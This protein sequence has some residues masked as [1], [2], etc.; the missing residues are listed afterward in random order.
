MPDQPG[1]T[2]PADPPAQDRRAS[3]AV[4]FT[5]I[6]RAIAKRVTDS[7]SQP[8]FTVTAS[9]HVDALLALRS[10]LNTEPRPDGQDDRDD[11]KVSLN[12]LLIGAVG[13]AL[14]QHPGINASYTPENRGQ[15]LIH[16]R[17]NIG[18]AVDSPAGLM[19]PVLHDADHDSLT[20][21]ARKTTS[22]IARTQARDL[23]LDDLEDGTFTISNLGM[24]GIDHFTALLIP[25][26]GAILAI[27]GITTQLT[28]DHGEP[29]EH[30][31]LSYTLTAD[32]RIIDGA[33]AARFLRTL[34]SI[35]EQPRP[36]LD[37]ALSSS[38]DVAG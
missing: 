21:L 38:P 24:L 5:P 10:H 9:A 28:L 15:Q 27:G 17:I 37:K 20:D 11:Q 2:T 26:Q 33:L 18:I 16:D 35:L 6:R 7:A 31:R 29:T 25:P 8:T 14:R 13:L 12:D 4:P 34:T 36:A 32:H 3:R 1:P 19:V 22:L 30:R 23:T